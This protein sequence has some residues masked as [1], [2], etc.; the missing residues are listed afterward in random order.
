MPGLEPR[1][2]GSSYVRLDV[3]TANRCRRNGIKPVSAIELLLSSFIFA[4][5][6]Q[7]VIQQDRGVSMRGELQESIGWRAVLTVEVGVDCGVEKLLQSA[8]IR[9]VSSP[10][11]GR[12]E[13]PPSI[14]V[15]KENA[16]SIN[17]A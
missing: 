2:L 3:N 17:P 15:L 1:I 7:V 13:G 8:S 9:A 12:L 11:E 10:I 6:L 16:Q 4:D 5:L 14:P